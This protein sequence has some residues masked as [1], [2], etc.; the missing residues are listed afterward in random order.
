MLRLLVWQCSCVYQP[1]NFL[2]YGNGN[3]EKKIFASSV[4]A[5]L[6]MRR[7]EDADHIENVWD[8][9]TASRLVAID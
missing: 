5:C 3:A 4:V 7:K 8:V 1:F 6:G 9:G 2:G